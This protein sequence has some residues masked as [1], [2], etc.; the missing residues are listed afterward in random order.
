M[1]SSEEKKNTENEN[2]PKEKMEE[3]IKN[4]ITSKTLDGFMK[5][6]INRRR[7]LLIHNEKC[8][9]VQIFEQFKKKS[10]WNSQEIPKKSPWVIEECC[11]NGRRS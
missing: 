11:W 5:F 6:Y 4:A 7:T 1:R 8:S 3:N 2:H 10:N 9:F